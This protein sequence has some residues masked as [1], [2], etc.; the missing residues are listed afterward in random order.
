[1]RLR[2]GKNRRKKTRK[3]LDLPKQTSKMAREGITVPL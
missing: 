1:M 3:V 2:E